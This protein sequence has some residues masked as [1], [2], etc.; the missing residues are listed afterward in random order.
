MDILRIMLQLAWL[1]TLFEYSCLDNDS[2]Y[3]YSIGVRRNSLRESGN[4]VDPDTSYNK[5]IPI[6]HSDSYLER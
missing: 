5:Q 1:P 6:G 2:A 4:D 3:P